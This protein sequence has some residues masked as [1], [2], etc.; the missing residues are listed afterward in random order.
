[1]CSSDLGQLIEYGRRRCAQVAALDQPLRHGFA[2]ALLFDPGFQR[3]DVLG[4]AGGRFERRDFDVAAWRAK[5]YFD[6]L[7]GGR[8]QCGGHFSLERADQFAGRADAF[9]LQSCLPAGNEFLRPGDALHLQI[10]PQF[11]HRLFG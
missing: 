11:G 8:L 6:A 2:Q 9:R 7:L 5:G 10:V 1:M 3:A 4:A